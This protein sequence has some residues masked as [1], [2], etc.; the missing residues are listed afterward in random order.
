MTRPIS[1]LLALA[2]MLAFAGC[3]ASGPTH[4]D[5]NAFA[6]SGTVAPGG[7]VY[8]RNLDGPILVDSSGSGKVEINASARWRGSRGPL[9][10]VEHAT[11]DGIIVCS[12]YSTGGTCDQKHYEV[13]GHGFNMWSLFGGGRGH[14]AVSYVLRVPRGVQVDILTVNGQL[15]VANVDG[16]VKAH[17]VNGSVKVAAAGG[18]VNAATVNGS[19]VAALDSVA[20]TGEV[21]LE[22]VNGSVTAELP[23]KINGTVSLETV[24]GKATSDFPLTANPDDPKHLSGTLGTGG[25]VIKLT[26]VNGSV[27]LQR[28]T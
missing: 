19:V 25:R 2:G 13:K 8:I 17:T 15:G 3:S 4:I 18:A 11:T 1:T 28:G 20:G 12:M 5:P 24:T 10:F 7:T 23:P 26:T 9:H 16:S 14:A 6:W 22:T 27:T 21:K